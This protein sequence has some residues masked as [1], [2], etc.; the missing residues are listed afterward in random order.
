MGAIDPRLFQKV[1]DLI[2][3]AVRKIKLHQPHG[4]RSLFS[5]EILIE[6]KPIHQVVTL[7]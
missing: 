4:M 7:S 1:G 6:L 2:F 3:I 5:E